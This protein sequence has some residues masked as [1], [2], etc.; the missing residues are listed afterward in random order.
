MGELKLKRSKCLYC[1]KEFEVPAYWPGKYCSQECFHLSKRNRDVR[2]CKNCGKS[3]EV[4][5]SIKSIC[6]SLDCKYELLSKK[7]NFQK[8]YNCEHC[9]KTFMRKRSSKQ[10]Y[11][12]LQCKYDH[13]KNGFDHYFYTTKEWHRTR[14]LVLIRDNFTCKSCGSKFKS[15]LHVHH[16]IPKVYGGDES[17]ENLITLCNKCHRKI[18][19]EMDSNINLKIPSG[20]K[21]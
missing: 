3:F 13:D 17:L 20:D 12:S 15:K 11:C 4:K 18:H 19:L 5:K 2:I 21:E 10:K 9:G 16:L 1:G 7:R 6:C 14:S 8:E